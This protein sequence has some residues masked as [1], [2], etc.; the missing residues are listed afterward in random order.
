MAGPASWVHKDVWEIPRQA[1]D[2]N[3]GGKQQHHKGALWLQGE[4]APAKK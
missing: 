1:R 3:G 4:M 2:D